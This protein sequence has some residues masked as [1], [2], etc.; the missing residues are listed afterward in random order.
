MTGEELKEARRLFGFSQEKLGDKLHMTRVMIG[1][2]ERGEK[3]IEKRTELSV[4]CLLYEAGIS[5][6][7]DRATLPG[8]LR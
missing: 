7:G 4:W 2:M 6:S 8:R 1:L 3:P 5:T